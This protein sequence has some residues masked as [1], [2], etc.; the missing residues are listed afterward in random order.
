MEIY[1]LYQI[2]L[3]IIEFPGNTLL[4]ILAIETLYCLLRTPIANS[5]RH[6]LQD[7]GTVLFFEFSLPAEF[8]FLKHECGIMIAAVAVAAAKSL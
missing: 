6:L 7:T 8:E 3:V 2:N 1:L 5:R 4:Q